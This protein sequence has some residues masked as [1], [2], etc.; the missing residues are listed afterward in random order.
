[1]YVCMYVCMYVGGVDRTT[2]VRWMR[3]GQCHIHMHSRQLATR[4]GMI[5]I[6]GE[7]N[8]YLSA[9]GRCFDR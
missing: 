8:R 1:M 2:S 6:R 3:I 4:D 9:P 7:S 5:G